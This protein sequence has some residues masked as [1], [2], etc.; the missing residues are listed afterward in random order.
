MP[1]RRV[2]NLIICDLESERLPTWG[3][4]QEIYCLDTKKLYIIDNLSFRLLNG[5]GIGVVSWG[6]IT[7]SPSAQTDLSPYLL[8]IIYPIGTIYTSV[9]STNPASLFGIG[10]WEAFGS[11]R[12][13]V[14]VDTDQPEFNTVEETGGAKTH[15]LTEAEIPAHTHGYLEPNAPSTVALLGVTVQ[16]VA[17]RTETATDSTGGGGAH[18]NLQP[19]ITVY[20]FKRIS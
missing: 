13:L 12:V 20:Y 15:T 11:G 1:I 10:T 18:N 14:G 9:V 16:A 3:N 6:D 4:G 2:K 17:N 5:A 7:G 8:N 19:Y